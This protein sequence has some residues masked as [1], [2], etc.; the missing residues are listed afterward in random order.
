MRASCNMGSSRAEAGRD[1][2]GRETDAAEATGDLDRSSLARLGPIL[3]RT[4]GYRLT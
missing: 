2:T 3:P 4:S 1:E